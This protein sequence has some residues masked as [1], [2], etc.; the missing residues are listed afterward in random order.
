MTKDP[1]IIWSADE[2]S[3][4]MLREIVNNDSGNVLPQELGIKL[5]RLFLTRYGLKQIDV[6]QK[7]GY[8]VFADAKII[9]IPSKSLEIAADH[10]KYKPWMLNIMAGACSTGV[11]HSKQANEVDAL[12]RFADLCHQA[13]TRPCGVTVL[14]SKDDSKNTGMVF[15]EFRRTAKRQVLFY[16]GLLVEAGFTDIVCSPQEARV[17][18]KYSQFDCLT[19]NTPGIRLPNSQADDQARIMTPRRA[20]EAGADRLVIGRPLRE[21]GSFADNYTHIMDNIEGR[22][23]ERRL[24][25]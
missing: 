3:A 17:L 22:D 6:M 24:V 12:K 20:L 14:T 11:W 10:L 19:I 13:G 5:D 2:V 25:A 1:L 15:K 4:A 18:R 7:A 23:I 8:K 21:N 16:A 9:E